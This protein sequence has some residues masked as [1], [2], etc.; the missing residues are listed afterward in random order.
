MRVYDVRRGRRLVAAVEIVSPANKDRPERRRAFV[1][2]CTALLQAR[3]S[4]V[5]VDV[6]TTRHFNL[7]HELLELMSQTDPSLEPEPPALYSAACRTTRKRGDWLFET[8]FQPLTVGQLL[9]TLPLWL[10]DDLAIPLELD[11]TY[12]SACRVLRLP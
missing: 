11:T 2:K 6:V 8:W 12:E 1:A 10:S 9:P 5:M 7:Y 4:V 3:V